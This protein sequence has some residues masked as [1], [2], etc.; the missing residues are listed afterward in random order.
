MRD[1]GVILGNSLVRSYAN[2]RTVCVKV[3]VIVFLL[4]LCILV[5]RDTC[6]MTKMILTPTIIQNS[7]TP[8]IMQNSKTPSIKWNPILLLLSSK[9]ICLNLLWYHQSYPLR[10]HTYRQSHPILLE[11]MTV[12]VEATISR[13][14]HYPIIFQTPDILSAQGKHP[15]TSMIMFSID[16][17]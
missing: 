3:I 9:Q 11:L 7:M 8:T 12:T 14:H 2:C 17:V 5:C 13:H 6:Q 1:P 16:F 15:L 10:L 4:R